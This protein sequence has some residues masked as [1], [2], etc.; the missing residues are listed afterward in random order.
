MAPLTKKQKEKRA[1][2]E[3]EA[4]NNLNEAI[5]NTTQADLLYDI[6]ET[7]FSGFL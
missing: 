3:S 2:A 7:D 1:I 4:A 5:K 6:V